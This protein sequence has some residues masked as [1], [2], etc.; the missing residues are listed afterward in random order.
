MARRIPKEIKDQYMEW[1]LTP[2][3]EREPS[4]KKAFAETFDV[5]EKTLR[6]WEAEPAFQEQLRSLR[7]KWGVRWHGEILGE[8][9]KIVQ[10][11]APSL[12]IQAAKVLL[13]HLDLQPEKT[14]IDKSEETIIAIKEKMK[15]EGWKVLE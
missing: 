10:E 13:Q 11:G 3:G 7:A 2:P 1:L 4:T 14:A 9:M 12:K 8:L 6:N 15:E 5:A